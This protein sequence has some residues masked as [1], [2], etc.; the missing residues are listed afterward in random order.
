MENNPDHYRFMPHFGDEDKEK[1]DSRNEGISEEA[2]A[3]ETAEMSELSDPSEFF[4]STEHSE[5]SEISENSEEAKESD[6]SAIDMGSLKALYTF[7]SPFLAPTYATLLIFWFSILAIIAP[8]AVLPYALTIFG[9]TGMLPLITL[10]IL[11]RIGAIESF[12]LY[13]QRERIIPYIVEILAL[14]AVTIFYVAKGATPWIWTI[15]CGATAV[16]LINF[17]INFK[18]RISNHCSAMAAL[19]AAILVVQIYG[20]PPQP[21]YWWAIGVVFFAGFA[22]SMAIFVGRHTVWE[23][24]TG[25]ATGF[26]GVILFSLIH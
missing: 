18:F 19:L 5:D 16:A 3:K 8:R 1:L 20:V 6:S 24:I 15:F 13:S 4:E 25:Y 12:Q 17:F 14:G 10:F 22:G 21:L 2:E 11:R 9:A 26:L 23:V 7:T